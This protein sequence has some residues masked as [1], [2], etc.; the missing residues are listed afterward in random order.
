MHKIKKISIFDTQI[1]KHFRQTDGQEIPEKKSN[2]SDNV[3]TWKYG[4]LVFP[5]G[6][7]LNMGFVHDYQYKRENYPF[8]VIFDFNEDEEDDDKIIVN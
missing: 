8:D 3:Y 5:R 1:L 4:D 7:Q 2:L 6:R